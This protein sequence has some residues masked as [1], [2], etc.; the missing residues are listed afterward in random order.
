MPMQTMIWC[1]QEKFVTRRFELQQRK[2]S[3]E[4]VLDQN[5]FTI[6]DKQLEHSCTAAQLA[7]S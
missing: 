1:F 4:I 6:K 2:P 3:K 5:A 7:L